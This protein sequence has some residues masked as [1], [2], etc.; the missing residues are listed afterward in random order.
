MILN[1]RVLPHLEK[2]GLVAFRVPADEQLRRRLLQDG[3]IVSTSVNRSGEEPLEDY[4]Q[5][6]ER[7]GDWFDD[8]WVPSGVRKAAGTPS[9]V[10]KID[11][12][13]LVCLREGLLDF[14]KVRQVWNALG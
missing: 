11:G 4:G 8:D 9:T 13:K 1:C 3:A 6:M 14:A 7:C 12:E 2:D 5:I 10:V